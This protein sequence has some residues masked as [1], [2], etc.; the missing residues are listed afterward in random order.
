MDDPTAYLREFLAEATELDRRRLL[1]SGYRPSLDITL[2]EQRFEDR[3]PRPDD[4]DL[5]SFL[6]GFR[7]FWAKR[8]RFYLPKVYPIAQAALSD[9]ALRAR[10]AESE[11]WLSAFEGTGI[12]EY[13]TREQGGTDRT[14]SNREL[15]D[16]WM[17]GAYFHRSNERKTAWWRQHDAMTRAV[18]EWQLREYVF[19]YSGEV[20]SVAQ[21]LVDAGGFEAEPATPHA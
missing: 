4:E 5:R 8:E 17:H 7:L 21:V 12:V 16:W 9:A 15:A 20:F 1:V 19:S 10:L 11:R 13:R 6:M 14:W 2:V 3:S 18:L